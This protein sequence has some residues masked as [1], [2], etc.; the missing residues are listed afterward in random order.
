[1]VP[2][3]HFWFILLLLCQVGCGCWAATERSSTAHGL[4][5]FL[6]AYFK[7]G[8]VGENVFF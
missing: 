8:L 2:A 1:M 6:P 7:S 4:V 5:A 3:V